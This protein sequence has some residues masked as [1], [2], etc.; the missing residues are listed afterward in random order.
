VNKQVFDTIDNNSNNLQE[1]KI[2]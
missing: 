2:K 1:H